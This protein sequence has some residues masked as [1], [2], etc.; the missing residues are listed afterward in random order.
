LASGHFAS[1]IGGATYNALTGISSLG[2]SLCGGVNTY[3]A[4]YN[5]TGT[6]YV[7]HMYS[8][9][10]KTAFSKPFSF[11]FDDYAGYSNSYSVSTLDGLSSGNVLVPRSYV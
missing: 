4:T 8:A 2:F 5:P 6:D 9:A 10:N 1:S 3:D 11:Y 7:L